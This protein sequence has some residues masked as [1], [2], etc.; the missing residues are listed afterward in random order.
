MREIDF[1]VLWVDGNDP[2]WLREKSKYVISKKADG[3]VERYRDFENL[4]YLFRGI[5]KYAPW[6]RKV[7]FV[8]YGHLPS[9]LNIKHPKLSI[10]NHKDFIPEK[11]LPTFSANTIEHNLYRIESLSEQFVYF[12][13]DMFL[14]NSVKPENF[15][16]DGMPKDTAALNVHCYK[17]SLK[18]QLMCVMDTGIINEHFNFH[19]S[20]KHDIRKWI[21]PKYGKVIFRTLC[22]LMCP[23]F[24]GFY[25]HHLPS[26]L[27]KKTMRNLWDIEY[28]I[29]DE[30]C[31]HKFREQT[32]V[33]QWLYK[34]WE[35]ASGN[36]VPRSNKFGKSFFIDRDGV[37]ILPNVC[38]YIE[39][40]KGKIIAINDGEMNDDQFETVKKELINSFDKILPKKSSFEL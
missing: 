14:I 21:N 4:Q 6:V 26:S 36:F 38:K 39:K 30:T 22:L 33:N 1:V 20:I 15:F 32:D 19:D 11:Y 25:Q 5:E 9:W 8:T 27:L 23:R 2:E 10:V 31:M 16:V 40:Q 28:E 29:L 7:H 12:N 18:T 3:N 37:D 35:L 17:K 34:E 13:D 24:P